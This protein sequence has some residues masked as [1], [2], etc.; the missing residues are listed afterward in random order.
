M[1]PEHNT[2]KVLIVDDDP[3]SI[4]VLAKALGE[5]YRCEFALSGTAALTRLTTGDPPDLLLLD[6][7]MPEMD[8]YQVC[9]RLRSELHIQDLPVICVTACND[10]DSETRALEAGASDFITKP[11]NPRVLRLRAGFQ[12]LLRKRERALSRLNAELEQRVEDRTEALRHALERA[13]A[14]DRAKSAFLS[15]ISH[16]VRTPLNAIMGLTYLL[17][18]DLSSPKQLDWLDKINAAANRLL[19]LVG[20][21]LQFSSLEATK[22]ELKVEDFSPLEL[23]E[24]LSATVADMAETKGLRLIADSTNLPPILRGDVALLRQALLG[25]LMNA[26]KFT[27]RGEVSLSARVVEE[28]NTDLI[29]HFDVTDTGIGINE[30]QQPKLFRAFEQADD[31]ATRAHTGTGLGLAITQGIAKLMSGSVGV[32]TRLGEGSRFWLRVRI[33]KPTNA[34]L[35]VSYPSVIDTVH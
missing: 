30:D 14:A 20:D 15:N 8:G 7:M 34:G 16:E 25:Y 6:L 22:L 21:I 11:V 31:S 19:V 9:H 28:T 3:T 13:E 27:E 32:D 29:I 5:G 24:Q 35:P 4:Q 33:D 1:M 17:G 26:I 23:F 18:R 10:P 12:L 2:P